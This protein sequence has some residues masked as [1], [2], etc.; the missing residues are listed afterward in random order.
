[1][2][3]QLIDTLIKIINSLSKEERNLLEDNLFF[4]SSEPSTQ[5]LINLAQASNCFDFL[6]NEPDLYSLKDGE[7][8]NEN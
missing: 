8:I 3:T 4:S 5:D 2:N 6:A 1:M 7:P